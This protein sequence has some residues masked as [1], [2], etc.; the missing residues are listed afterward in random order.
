LRPGGVT[1]EQLL[2]HV[3]D[4][5]VDAASARL[6]VAQTAPGQLLRHYAPDAPVTMFTGEAI[7]VQ[8]RLGAEARTAVGKGH[9]VGILAPEEDIL[10]LAPVLAAAATTGRVLLRAYGRRTAPEQAAQALFEALRALDAEHPDVILA[11]DV[12][13]EGLGAAV[14]DRLTR[15]AEGRVVRV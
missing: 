12:G 14:R 15:A 10:A 2:V 1:R 7:A 5:V 13:T 6:E 4:L 8:Q 3:P 9:R 11:S